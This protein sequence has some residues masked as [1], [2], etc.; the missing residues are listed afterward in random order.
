MNGRTKGGK[1][2]VRAKVTKSSNE[3]KIVESHYR[4]R[5]E[6]AWQI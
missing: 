3:K 5:P 1:N 2:G 4:T 6:W